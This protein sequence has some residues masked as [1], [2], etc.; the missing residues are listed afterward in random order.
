MSLPREEKQKLPVFLKACL[1][2]VVFRIV[3][4][5]TTVVVRIVTDQL[6]FKGAKESAP[7]FFLR[8][9]FF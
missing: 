1:I 3:R 5:V 4:I 9:F 2:S 6:R 7:L 8:F